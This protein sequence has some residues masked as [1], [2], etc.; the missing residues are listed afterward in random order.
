MFLSYFSCYN[1]SHHR[2]NRIVNIDTASNI[3]NVEYLN[4]VDIQNVV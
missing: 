3:K 1:I 2:G 4:N